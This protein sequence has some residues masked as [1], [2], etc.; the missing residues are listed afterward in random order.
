MPQKTVSSGASSRLRKSRTV[1]DC[2]C[3]GGER[4]ATAA[5]C[6][7]EAARLDTPTVTTNTSR[8]S[9][10]YLGPSCTIDGETIRQARHWSFQPTQGDVRSSRTNGHGSGW[11]GLKW[12]VMLVS[13]SDWA[14]Y[15]SAYHIPWLGQLG[16]ENPTNSERCGPS[17]RVCQRFKVTGETWEL[18]FVLLSHTLRNEGDPGRSSLRSRLHQEAPYYC[19][20]PSLSV[21]L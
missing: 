17:L 2:A 5:S 6:G 8:G 4:I 13:Q 18:A 7:L 16:Q 15:R 14:G 12:G 19:K 11:T 9:Q 21:S 3:K 20:S 1:R 10:N